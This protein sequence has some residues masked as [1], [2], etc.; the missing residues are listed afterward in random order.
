MG[1]CT[2][3]DDDDEGNSANGGAAV[4]ETEMQRRKAAAEDDPANAVLSIS[5]GMSS[6]TIDIQDR[7]TVRINFL[8]ISEDFLN[9]SY[10]AN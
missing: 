1:C 10:C 5:R 8:L 3:K 4:S 2:S 9:D 7:T 6:K